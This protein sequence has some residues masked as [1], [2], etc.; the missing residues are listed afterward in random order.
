MSYLLL[1]A[2]ASITAVA[3]ILFKFGIQNA[4]SSEGEIRYFLTLMRSPSVLLGVFFFV[5]GFFIWMLGL[6]EV[7]VSRAYA[8]VALGIVLVSLFG[9]L[10][11][12]ER[13]S[14]QTSCG[15]GLIVFGLGLIAYQST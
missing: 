4:S 11:L 7:P 5:I 6:R 13:I 12:A 9:H 1:V 15:I 10:F 14:L 8:F 3:Q 2:S